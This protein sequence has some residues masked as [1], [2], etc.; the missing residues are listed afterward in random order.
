MKKV[1]LS[2]SSCIYFWGRGVCESSLL[3][4]QN[5][6]PIIVYSVAN[7]TPHVCHFWANLIFVIPT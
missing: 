6:F 4:S 2:K 1:N 3:A 5:P 7:Y